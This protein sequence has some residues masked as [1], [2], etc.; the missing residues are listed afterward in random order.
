MPS[1]R[2]S[3]RAAS[4]IRNQHRRPDP[5][6]NDAAAQWLAKHGPKLRKR[7]SRSSFIAIYPG[8]CW[9]CGG[10]LLG[11]HCSYGRKDVLVHTQT[12]LE[13]YR[14]LLASSAA[15]AAKPQDADACSCE[16]HPPAGKENSQ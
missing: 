6:V 2:S 16:S 7:H 11:Q 5:T 3:R 14:L 12:C 9:M 1:S 10:E 8:A 13:A 15:Q 4:I